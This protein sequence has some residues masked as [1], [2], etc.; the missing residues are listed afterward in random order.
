MRFSQLTDFTIGL[1]GIAELSSKG[2]KILDANGFRERMDDLIFSAVFAA[3]ENVKQAARWIIWEG[4]GEL[5]VHSASIQDLYMAR[6]RNDY[7]DVCVPA[8]NLRGMTYESARA[9]VRAVREMDGGPFIIEIA[10]SEMGY[11]FQNPSEFVACVLAGAVREGYTGPVCIQGDH[12]QVKASSYHQDAKKEVDGVKAL[13]E[14]AVAAGFYNIDIDTSTLVELDKPTIPEQQK[15]NFT[16]AAELTEHVRKF[17]PEGVTIS[18]GGEIG[19]VGGKNSTVEE[20]EA[21]LDGYLDTLK[22]LNPAYK[23]ISKIS[24]QTGTSHGGVPLPDGSVA[25]VALDFGVLEELGRV[26]RDKYGLSGAV[27]HGASTLPDEAFHRFKETQTAEVHLATGFQNLV[28]DHPRFPAELK[29][30]IYAWLKVNCRA[31]WKPSLTEEQFLYKTRKKGYGPY[32]PEFWTMP[33]ETEA[34]LME[35]LQ[36]KFSFLFDQLGLPNSRHL[37]KEFLKPARVKKEIPKV[38]GQLLSDPSLFG[39]KHGV[40]EDAPGAD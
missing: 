15:L 33:K 34:A 17:E 37:V 30:R 3:D 5:G 24:I 1:D 25:E 12:F 13:I 10:K 20:L 7:K 11:T 18:V 26:A 35:G 38:F 16:I 22:S 27:Q 6:G 29:D 19:E 8:V 4:A 23:G 31:D 9:L 14:D 32:K 28:Y 2:V 39:K 40:E 36:K 21:Y